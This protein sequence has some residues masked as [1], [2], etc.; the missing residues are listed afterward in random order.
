MF[1]E[2]E[3]RCIRNTLPLGL[4]WGEPSERTFGPG[5]SD[6]YTFELFYRLQLLERLAITP[7]IQ[8]LVD[9][10]LNPDTE[11]AAVF[12]LRARLAF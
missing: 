11:V 2:D 12:G 5:L 10:A 7:D 1:P 3:S 9:P 6:Q 4:H 8:V